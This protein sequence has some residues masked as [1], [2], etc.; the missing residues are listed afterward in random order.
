MKLTRAHVRGLRRMAA[1]L[2][3]G[4][5]HVTPEAFRERSAELARTE[6]MMGPPY[7]PSLR[8]RRPKR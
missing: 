1:R 4:V 8:W 7:R 6:R 3:R 5:R 2:E